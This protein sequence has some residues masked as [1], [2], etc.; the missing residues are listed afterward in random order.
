MKFPNPL[1]SLNY[2]SRDSYLQA[3]KRLFKIEKQQDNDDDY[4]TSSGALPIKAI[5]S[6]GLFIYIFFSISLSNTT[7]R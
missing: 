4:K 7:L 6:S 1:S 2:E 5:P 3:N